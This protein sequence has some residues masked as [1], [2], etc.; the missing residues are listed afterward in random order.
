[1]PQYYYADTTILAFPDTQGRTD[2]F[3]DSFFNF[4][5]GDVATLLLGMLGD[6]TRQSSHG[7]L[8]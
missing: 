2:M 3:R 8:G 5:P 6:S 7:K 1:M 4:A